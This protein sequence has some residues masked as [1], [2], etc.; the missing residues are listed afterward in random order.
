MPYTG[1]LR[2]AVPAL[3]SALAAAL[4]PAVGPATES[5]GI[6]ALRAGPAAVHRVV[7]LTSYQGTKMS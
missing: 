1:P 4:A 3:T 7:S 2:T 5:L 6:S